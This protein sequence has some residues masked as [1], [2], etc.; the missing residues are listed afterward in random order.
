MGVEIRAERYTVLIDG[1]VGAYGV[2]FPDLPG[3]TAMGDTVELALE[4]AG[5]ALRDWTLHM[6]SRGRSIPPARSLDAVRNDPE[7]A[8]A[9]AEGATLAS[10]LLVRGV[11]RPVKANLSLDAGVLAAIDATAARLGLT[12]SATV[13]LLAT[14]G[15]PEL[16]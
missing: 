8:E 12:R 14:R 4:N 9:L 2:V 16:A 5:E 3:C 7:A 11:G 15:L 10:V 13:E 6:E 1:D